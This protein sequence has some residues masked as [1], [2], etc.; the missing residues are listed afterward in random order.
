MIEL[1]KTLIGVGVL[2]LGIP[3]GNI[4]ANQTKEEL[5]SRQ[6]YFMIIVWVGLIGGLAGLI[7]GND[8]IMFSL[9]FIAIVTSRSLI[10]KRKKK[11]KP[12]A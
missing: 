7:L 6:N 10:G 11:I 5:Q 12:L 1:L 8:A 9:F 4:L 3:I 2:A